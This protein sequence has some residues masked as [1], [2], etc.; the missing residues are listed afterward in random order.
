VSE[1]PNLAAGVILVTDQSFV[2]P[3]NKGRALGGVLGVHES[4]PCMN[5]DSVLILSRSL[6]QYNLNAPFVHPQKKNQKK[7]K[8]T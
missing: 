5:V 1:E 4:G 3:V 7:K 2:L 8:T 6:N